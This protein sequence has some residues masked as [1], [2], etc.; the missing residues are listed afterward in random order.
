MFVFLGMCVK[1]RTHNLYIW[2][3]SII[4]KSEYQKQH[5]FIILKFTIVHVTARHL[6]PILD[7]TATI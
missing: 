1:I 7:Q 4:L 2:L 6:F 5:Q 3:F